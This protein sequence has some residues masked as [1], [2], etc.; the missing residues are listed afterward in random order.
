MSISSFWL[1]LLGLAA[2][3]FVTA[4]ASA[5]DNCLA[6]LKQQADRAGLASDT[7][8]H[9]VVVWSSARQ[10]IAPIFAA[11]ARCLRGAYRQTARRKINGEAGAFYGTTT[12]GGG[13]ADVC[14]LPDLGRMGGRGEHQNDY[15]VWVH[16]YH[17]GSGGEFSGSTAGAPSG[18]G[19]L[20]CSDLTQLT[21][22]ANRFLGSVLT[23][24]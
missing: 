6:Q 23:G 16:C 24:R 1:V 17:L 14:E 9:E 20:N 10:P 22:C 15:T 21:A 12:Q 8:N 7:G 11:T 19:Q 5:N 18:G 2:A 4:P 3:L 13:G